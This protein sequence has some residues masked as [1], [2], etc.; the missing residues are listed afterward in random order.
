MIT[1]E[2]VDFFHTFGY[3]KFPGL[4]KAEIKWISEEFG[5]I[6]EQANIL[7]DGKVVSNVDPFIDKSPKLA[8]LLDDERIETI[9]SALLGDDFNYMNS[10]GKYYVGNTLWHRDGLLQDKYKYIK[11]AF[12]LDPV[13]YDS[14]ALRVIPG[15]HKLGDRYANEIGS[16]HY[17]NQVR[18]AD[19]NPYWGLK[20]QEVPSQ[21]LNSNPGD[22]VIFCHPLYHSSWG[23]GERRRMFTMNLCQ[24]YKDEDLAEL[25]GFFG[26]HYSEYSD[27]MLKAVQG[28]GKKHLEQGLAYFKQKS[29]GEI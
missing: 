24:R 16:G 22:V 27:I 25:R 11:V 2:Q 7:H 9:S 5:K 3:I 6:F 15:S 14:G 29:K 10:D 21:V 17:L 26:D 1:K 19:G 23:G 20:G 18:Q 13:D 12:Y 4:F 28:K 8:A